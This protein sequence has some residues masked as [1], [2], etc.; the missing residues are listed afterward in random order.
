M[1]SRG[2]IFTVEHRGGQRKAKPQGQEPV[3]R[4]RPRLGPGICCALECAAI[5]AML[6]VFVAV[7]E[8]PNH[9]AKMQLRRI[10]S[11]LT[12]LIQRNDRLALGRVE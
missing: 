7:D 8:E 3:L 5:H 6:K 11:M 12:R 9:T 2:P 1:A 4:D 10:V